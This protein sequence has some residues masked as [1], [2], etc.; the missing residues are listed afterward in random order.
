MSAY[1]LL[2]KHGNVKST[3][4]GLQYFPV[5]TLQ[6]ISVCLQKIIGMTNPKQ[7]LHH[8]V[9]QQRFGSCHFLPHNA[10]DVPQ[11]LFLK[12]I[13]TKSFKDVLGTQGL[14]EESS[15]EIVPTLC[16]SCRSCFSLLLG[17]RILQV[18]SLQ[19]MPKLRTSKLAGIHFF[20]SLI[21]QLSP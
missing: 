10:R 19:N 12:V 8:Q 4:Y 9:G 11:I 13:G 5:K 17:N 1:P 16:V 18:E 14:C 6:G 7:I 15:H 20:T 2:I 3:I 21:S